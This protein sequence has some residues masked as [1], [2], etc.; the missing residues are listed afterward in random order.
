MKAL[1]LI[2]VIVF[3][4]T[5]SHG[6][7]KE[8]DYKKMID[9]AII[10]QTTGYSKTPYRSGIYLIDSKDQIYILTSNTD[11]KK[12]GYINVYDK[13]NKKLLKKGVNVWKVLPVLS[14]NK[15]VVSIIDFNVTYKKNNYNFANVG[16]ATVTFEY[17]CDQNK[18]VFKETNW[19]GI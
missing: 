6:Q 18:W 3:S 8:D 11:K 2:F 4:C 12:F 15:L 5:V 10:M 7:V 16:G 17:L 9:T 1:I 14:G 19:S 13:K